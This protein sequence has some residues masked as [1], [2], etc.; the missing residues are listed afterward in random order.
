MAHRP[1]RLVGVV[2]GVLLA[3]LADLPMALLTA[4]A[5]A[6]AVVVVGVML[7][8]GTVSIGD[9][10]S[11]ATTASLRRPLVVVRGVRGAGHRRDPGPTHRHCAAA[12]RCV[13]HG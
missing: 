5:G 1:G 12:R 10:G 11:V 13:R 8:V 4:M 2:G 7:L 3:V 6:T 9:F